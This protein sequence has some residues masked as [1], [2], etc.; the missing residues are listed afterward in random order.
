MV[1]GRGNGRKDT[2][3][4]SSYGL[5][6]RDSDNSGGDS[7]SPESRAGG[8]KKFKQYLRVLYRPKRLHYSTPLS[9]R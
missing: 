5:R 4:V 9:L 7:G 3:N 8:G 1:G 6:I 2:E